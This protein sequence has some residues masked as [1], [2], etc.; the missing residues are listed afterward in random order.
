MAA[1]RNELKAKLKS[2]ARCVGAWLA[3][4]DATA[5]EIAAQ[6]G[7]D[8]LLID[9]E[10][11]PNDLQSTVAQLRALGD[12]PAVVRLPDD[13]AAKIK[14]VLDIGAQTLLVPM[15][16]SATQ[17]E[18]IVRATRYPPQGIRGVGSALARATLYNTVPDYVATANDQICVIVQVES[19]AAVA[20]LDD[21]L[22]VEGVDGVFVGPADLSADMGLAI[23]D[24]AAEALVIDTLARIAASD[25]FAG[26]F[27]TSPTIQ[28]RAAKVGATFLGVTADVLVLS[29][30]LRE[31]AASWKA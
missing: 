6:S 27:S 11:S 15:V 5:A 23:D 10:H 8:W 28:A 25:K 20:A 22:G 12:V 31:I 9:G 29:Q 16:E 3:M 17:A 18:A 1:P 26:V 14:Q 7:L 24:P 30:G 13:D 21:I 19:Q 4:V 2:G